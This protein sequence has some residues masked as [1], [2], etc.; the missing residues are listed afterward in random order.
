MVSNLPCQRTFTLEIQLS[1]NFF[2]LEWLAHICLKIMAP[3]EITASFC[4]WPETDPLDGTLAVF[5]PQRA[6]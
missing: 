5:P 6:I 2:I 4:K 1:D 3:P